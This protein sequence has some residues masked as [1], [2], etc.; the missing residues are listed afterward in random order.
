VGYAAKPPTIVR[1][2]LLRNVIEQ[3]LA[4]RPDSRISIVEGVCT[5][6]PAEE[7]F[8]LAGLAQLRSERVTVLDAERLPMHAFPLRHSSA[9]C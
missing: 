5:K 6:M 9:Q 1:I 2:D 8:R 7:V 3:L 4:L